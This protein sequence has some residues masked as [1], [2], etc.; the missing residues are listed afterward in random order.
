MSFSCRASRIVLETKGGECMEF[1]VWIVL[2]ALAGWVASM[3]MHTDAEQ[4][5]L[6]NI[7]LGI[8]GAF[9][10]GFV[11][12]LFGASGVTGFNL[13][14]VLVAILGAVIVI[15]IGKTFLYR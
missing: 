4:G 1:L 2:G 5:A 12:N 10:G 11:M 13:Y 9:V 15:G 14:S 8:I 3:V 6:M 7:V